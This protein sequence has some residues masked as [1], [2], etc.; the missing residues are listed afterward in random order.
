MLIAHLPTSIE[1]RDLRLRHIRISDGPFISELLEHD[2]ILKSSGI[3]NSR[4]SGGINTPR[5]TP[6]F[7]LYW[8][9]RR[10]FLIAYCIE[11]ESRTIG[12]IGLSKPPIGKSAEI[13]LVIFDPISRRRGFG[14]RAFRVLCRVFYILAPGNILLVKVRNDNE[15]ALS[16][17]SKLGFANPCSDGCMTTMTRRRPQETDT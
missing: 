13:S 8:W 2:D 15:A 7:L 6:W 5:R 12:F 3:C 11:L 14:T 10:T 4:Q 9:L 16:F 1:D 17:W